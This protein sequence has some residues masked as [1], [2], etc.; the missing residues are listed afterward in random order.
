MIYSLEFVHFLS[1]LNQTVLQGFK[2]FFEDIHLVIKNYSLNFPSQT[3]EF[4]NSN[5]KVHSE[6]TIL[7]HLLN[8]F[9]TSRGNLIY[10]SRHDI[11]TTNLS[12]RLMANG[13]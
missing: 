3:M 12:T 1:A 2:I 8:K 6:E 13:L 10:L 9:C 11:D 7:D 5:S 4:T